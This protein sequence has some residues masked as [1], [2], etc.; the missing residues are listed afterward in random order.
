M[1]LKNS[2]QTKLFYVFAAFGILFSSVI[3]WIDYEQFKNELYK[4]ES[5]SQKMIEQHI[6]DNI[7]NIDDAYYIFDKDLE[8]TMKKYSEFLVDHY[9]KNPD[10]HA[11]NYQDLKKQVGG[12]DIYVIEATKK[13]EAVILNSSFQKDIG[14]NFG[15]G[16]FSSLLIKRIQG[17]EFNVDGMDLEEKTG[18]IRKYSYIPT[19]DH[20]YL[21]ELGLLL[22]D[23]EIF[24]RF[25]FLKT[26]DKMQKEYHQV[27]DVTLFNNEGKSIG[28]T[29]AKGKSKQLKGEEL[30]AVEQAMKTQ[31]VVTLNKDWKGEKAIYN[32][33]PYKANSEKDSLTNNRV[34]EIVFNENDLQSALSNSLQ[35]FVIKL[36]S[37]LV[38]SMIIAIVVAK[39]TMKPITETVTEMNQ[40]QHLQLKSEKRT[41]V[42]NDEFGQISRS[43]DAMRDTLIEIVQSLKQSS[44]SLFQNAV[45]IQQ[46]VKFAQKD[47]QLTALETEEMLANFSNTSLAVQNIEASVY[48][49][50]SILVSLTKEIGNQLQLASENKNAA[51]HMQKQ[52][53]ESIQKAIQVYQ[54]VKTKLEEALEQSK[55]VNDIHQIANTILE[56]SNQTDLLS[57]NAQ[58][59]SA[60]IGELGKGFHVVANEIKRLSEESSESVSNIQNIIKSVNKAVTDLS[61]QS[62]RALVFIEENVLVDYNK[63]HETSEKHNEDAEKIHQTL[64]TFHR[65]FE[66]V[67]QAFSTIRE[68]IE[69]T[70][71]AMQENTEA[72]SKIVKQTDSI[73]EQ[74]NKI[75][76]ISKNNEESAKTLKELVEKFNEK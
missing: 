15:V 45:S 4:K 16:D 24:K 55:S 20:K 65:S 70:N 61:E 14:L 1:K 25:D 40:I 58:V 57:I 12:M 62:S 30:Q 2:V 35:T 39:K 71:K 23:G 13:N 17:N 56:I 60:R 63:F 27:Y 50:E 43:L 32:Y 75:E 48:Q 59:E 53:Q 36:I 44:S 49:I 41:I 5:E 31:K 10:I 42:R 7:R 34:I 54:D 26:A 76:D 69:N 21:I 47:S 64:T 11:W 33:V 18:K 46:S 68:S 8:K 28:K 51:L 74:T 38:V 72:A 73:L 3:S 66:E 67:S 22:E 52:S 9:Q 29:D 6:T 19:P 37:I